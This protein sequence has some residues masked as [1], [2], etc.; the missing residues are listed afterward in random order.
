MQILN[1]KHWCVRT[2]GRPPAFARSTLSGTSTAELVEAWQDEYTVLGDRV[3]QK[4]LALPAI[5]A[6]KRITLVRH[7]Q[8]TWNAE[9]R[10]QGSSNHSVL[11]EKGIRQAKATAEIVGVDGC[12]CSMLTLKRSDCSTMQANCKHANISVL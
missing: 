2:F 10:V 12:S 8:S 7:G 11:T 6:P 5:A 1:T 3:A 9:S 4:P